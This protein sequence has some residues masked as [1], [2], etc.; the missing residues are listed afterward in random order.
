[1]RNEHH[2]FLEEY[3]PN[4]FCK[5]KFKWPGIFP[6]EKMKFFQVKF[7]K[8]YFFVFT[9]Q[10]LHQS[11]WVRDRKICSFS[12]P[13]SLKVCVFLCIITEATFSLKTKPRL[14]EKVVTWPVFLSSDSFSLQLFGLALQ[15][16]I[17]DPGFR[18]HQKREGGEREK[19]TKTFFPSTHPTHLF[20]LTSLLFANENV[21]LSNRISLILPFYL[22]IS[23]CPLQ[24][25]SLKQSKCFCAVYV[26]WVCRFLGKLYYY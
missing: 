1:M 26:V 16:E 11:G 24:F 25:I 3:F 17:L 9:Q 22:S 12:L 4:P 13:L 15:T 23:L 18:F 14:V 7:Y 8:F 19:N 20:L 2:Y 6:V 21:R 5:I 10:H